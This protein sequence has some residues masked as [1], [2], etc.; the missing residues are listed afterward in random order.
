MVWAY[1][2]QRKLRRPAFMGPFSL[3]ISC[4]APT[5]GA[6]FQPVSYPACLQVR[7]DSS[8]EAS[9]GISCTPQLRLVPLPH[10]CCRCLSFVASEVPADVAIVS[11][12]SRKAAYWTVQADEL[13]C[14]CVKMPVVHHLQALTNQHLACEAVLQPPERPGWCSSERGAL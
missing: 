9:G 8:P 14:V 12:V 11:L 4:T 10:S 3:E 6:M 13:C 5:P 1:T 2:L 7:R